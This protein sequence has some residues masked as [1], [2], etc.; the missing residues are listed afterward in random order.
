MRALGS[1]AALA[2][3]PP[4]FAVTCALIVLDVAEALLE[5]RAGDRAGKWRP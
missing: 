5:L 4:R 3:L 1:L 2:L